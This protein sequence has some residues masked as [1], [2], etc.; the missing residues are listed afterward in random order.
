[1]EETKEERK[2]RLKK[3]YDENKE[4]I[5]EYQKNY[6]KKFMTQKINCEFCQ[7]KLSYGSYSEHK[8]ICKVKNK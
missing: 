5:K 4:A 8:K 6:M 7:K 1:M 3:Y 2:E